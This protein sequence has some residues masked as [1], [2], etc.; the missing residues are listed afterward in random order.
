MKDSTKP[1]GNVIRINERDPGS[2]LRG[3]VEETRNAML[4]TEADDM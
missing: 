4:D 2:M 3:T 1:L